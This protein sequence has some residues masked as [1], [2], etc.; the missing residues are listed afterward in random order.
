M[1][2]HLFLLL[3][4]PLCPR[5][6]FVHTQLWAGFVYFMNGSFRRVKGVGLLLLQSCAELSVQAANQ[7][8]QRQTVLQESSSSLRQHLGTRCMQSSAPQ[9]DTGKHKP[10]GLYF[11]CRC[12]LSAPTVKHFFSTTS[13]A[14]LRAASPAFWGLRFW[15]FNLTAACI[16]QISASL[17]LLVFNLTS[18][19][20]YLKKIKMPLRLP[21]LSNR[22]V[23]RLLR[24]FLHKK[25]LIIADLI[26]FLYSGFCGFWAYS[27]CFELD[28]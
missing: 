12:K 25:L 18:F 8:C 24:H 5:S 3:F 19:F 10:L 22:N 11:I 15:I 7:S 9:V 17:F 23:Y 1:T 27:P 2:T 4:S 13:A 6:L 21:R 26:F 28:T 14:P 16:L 20:L